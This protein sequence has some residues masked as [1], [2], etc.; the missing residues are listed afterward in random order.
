MTDGAASA[1][2]ATTQ[3]RPLAIDG[4]VYF[5]RA[6]LEDGGIA[7]ELTDGA[8][9]WYGST[10]SADLNN[11]QAGVDRD[12]FARTVLAGLQRGGDGATFTLKHLH[13]GGRQLEWS[14]QREMAAGLFKKM[15]QTFELRSDVTGERLPRALAALVRE[16]AALQ[17]RHDDGGA[18]A[19]GL[20]AR[21]AELEAVRAQLDGA[22]ERMREEVRQ[23]C[24]DELNRNKRRIEQLDGALRRWE[25]RGAD[26]SDS[27][28]GRRSSESDDDEEA[29]PAPAVAAPA[30]AAAGP[31]GVA[32]A[33][34]D[35][36]DILDMA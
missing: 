3:F 16:A 32:P 28:G 33:A 21:E 7:L 8:E 10:P 24:L 15:W 4:A 18:R 35:D 9:S 34:D 1:S 20:A 6:W 14:V 13:D 36:D 5:L 19:R 22:R 27:D 17:Q 31:S 12:E 30:P 11:Q 2:A 26:D 29:A 23:R 25:E